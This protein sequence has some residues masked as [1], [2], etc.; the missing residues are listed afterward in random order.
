M[1]GLQQGRE[2][3]LKLKSGYSF[4]GIYDGIKEHYDISFH[5]FTKMSDE[6]I[7]KGFRGRFKNYVTGEKT[8]SVP[9]KVLEK[10]EI[11]L[12]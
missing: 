10:A 1:E 11:E 5:N 9:V 3:S 8:H 12:V 2:Y 6:K 7:E 4:A